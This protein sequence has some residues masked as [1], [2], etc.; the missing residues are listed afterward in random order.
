MP[1]FIAMFRFQF[2]M[3]SFWAGVAVA[4]RLL[5]DQRDFV[6]RIKGPCT[7]FLIVGMTIIYNL[8]FTFTVPKRARF[9]VVIVSVLITF[10]AL[11]F[12][13]FKYLQALRRLAPGP[14]AA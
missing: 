1:P 5:L 12:V 8:T 2:G 10:L 4:P 13:C 14:E 9:A 7:R 6:Q 11:N 3:F